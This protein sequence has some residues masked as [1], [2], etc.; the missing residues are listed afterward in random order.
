LAGHS[1]KL[2]PG[3]ESN[4]FSLFWRLVVKR[5]RPGAPRGLLVAWWLCE[6]LQKRF[7]P[8]RSV[9]G[10]KHRLL[11][12]R[13]IR[14]AGPPVVLRDSTPVTR[15]A[16]LGEVHMDN[17]RMMAVQRSGSGLLRATRDELTA[18][19]RWLDYS[20]SPIVALY[21]ETLIGAAAERIGFECR[22]RP[23]TFKARF[24]RGYFNG[25]LAL[26]NPDGLERLKRGRTLRAPLQY[27]W[28]SRRELD[29]HY[30]RRLDEDCVKAQERPRP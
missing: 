22:A 16:W 9:A 28:M 27:V 11:Q 12:L 24:D 18:I 23:M 19:A 2:A 30:R 25:L 1:L 29:K 7:Q 5:S 15:G 17:L 14:Y 4:E 13:V 6:Q 20:R 8:A 26:Y 21:G 10:S 3:R